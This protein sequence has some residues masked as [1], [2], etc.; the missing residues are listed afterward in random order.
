MQLI[1]K[2]L[3][4]QTMLLS[5]PPMSDIFSIKLNEQNNKYLLLSGQ[6]VLLAVE[7]PRKYGNQYFYEGGKPVITLK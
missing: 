7:L 6:K 5:H 1:T 4:A 2:L 3:S